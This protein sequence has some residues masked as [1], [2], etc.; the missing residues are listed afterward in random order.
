MQQALRS[1]LVVP[2]QQT[3]AGISGSAGLEL[4]AARLDYRR[5]RT[6]MSA[7]AALYIY[8]RR[9]RGSSAYVSRRHGEVPSGDL[10]LR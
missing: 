1:T 3:G 7:C 4:G 5:R 2:I 8:V 6:P 10:T 9:D